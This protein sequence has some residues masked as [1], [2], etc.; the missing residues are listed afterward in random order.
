[1]QV[2]V[3]FLSHSTNNVLVNCEYF[4]FRSFRIGILSKSNRQLINARMWFLH[5]W[6]KAE[7]FYFQ[8]KNR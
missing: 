2:K 4:L 3:R 1:M 7:K 8:F 5:K 6:K